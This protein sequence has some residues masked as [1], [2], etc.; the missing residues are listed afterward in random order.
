LNYSH[1]TYGSEET[2]FFVKGGF[3]GP[4]NGS[5][6]YDQL[7]NGIVWA[8]KNARD[9][10]PILITFFK[11]GHGHGLKNEPTT[12]FFALKQVKKGLRRH[13]LMN[14]LK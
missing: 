13:F 9:R 1:Q 3:L 8:Q 4:Q 2:L 11:K 6:L 12:P 7:T 14:L 5:W 10:V